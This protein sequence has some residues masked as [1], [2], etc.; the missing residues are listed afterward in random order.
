[1][2][3]RRSS[4]SY[5]PAVPDIVGV[6]EKYDWSN[7]ILRRGIGSRVY[8]VVETIKS[9]CPRFPGVLSINDGSLRDARSNRVG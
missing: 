6:S 5:R 7:R 2:Y 3:V 1:M 8:P 4:K 9:R